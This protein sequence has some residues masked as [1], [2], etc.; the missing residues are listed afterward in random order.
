MTD[1]HDV[2]FPL[3]LSVGSSASPERLTR[4]VAHG[5]GEKRAA[6]WRSSRRRFDATLRLRP[7][8]E[9]YRLVEFFEA[10]RGKLYGFR[11]RDFTDWKSCD[12]KKAPVATDQLLGIGDGE[13]RA[14]QLVKNYLSGGGSYARPIYKPVEGSI[15]AAVEGVQAAPIVSATGLLTF[16]TPPA[17]GARVT[18]GF[19]YDVPV[20]FDTDYLPIHLVSRTHGSVEDLP[21]VEIRPRAAG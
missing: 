11:W 10:R 6:A 16:A 15:L 17:E 12:R 7:H 9:L 21:V 8:D 4:I 14:F 18:A 19:L 2:L 20:R 5:G 1:F 13:T 3:R